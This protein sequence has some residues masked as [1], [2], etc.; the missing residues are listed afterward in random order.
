MHANPDAGM[1]MIVCALQSYPEGSAQHYLQNPKLTDLPNFESA[2]SQ[3]KIG[4]LLGHEI[5]KGESKYDFSH[6]LKHQ[7]LQYA[8]SGSLLDSVHM[9]QY[10]L[11]YEVTSKP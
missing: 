4:K 3:G 7:W 10:T 6:W 9:Q 1:G 8:G 5:L 2:A 11:R